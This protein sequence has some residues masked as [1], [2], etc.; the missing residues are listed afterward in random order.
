MKRIIQT[1]F[2]IFTI[3]ILSVCS[4][5]CVRNSKDIY[6]E[7]KSGL[8]LIKVER[9]HVL[10]FPNGDRMYFTGLSA[11]GTLENVTSSSDSIVSSTVYGTGFL[12]SDRGE[13]ATAHHVI[14]NCIDK[15][16][17]RNV[18]RAA[19]NYA[20]NDLNEEYNQAAELLFQL[21]MRQEELRNDLF[22]YDPDEEME[23]ELYIYALREKL[24]EYRQLYINLTSID[25]SRFDVSS[26]TEVGIAYNDTHIT[27][28]SDFISCVIVK[29]DEENDLA[30]I[31]LKDKFTP[32]NKY[33]F[34]LPSSDPIENYT[35]SE[36]I[37]R[38]IEKDKNDQLYLIGFNLGPSLALT[39]EGLMA[40]INQGGISQKQDSRLMYS[41]P[42]LPGSSG[43]PVVNS[44]GELVAV[45][46][47]GLGNTQ[48]FNYGIRVNLLRKLLK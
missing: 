26:V 34:S 28:D 14:S 4:I 42:A 35:F 12:I 38:H 25:P 41:I 37:M 3:F 1:I 16:E 22:Y 43:G 40:Q 10:T 5:S 30:V 24:E 9:H 21:N 8:V 32:S 18:I 47:A 39:S 19:I 29:E 6:E 48:S 44:R 17:V 20:K 2:Q 36:K 23:N 33:I 11:D 13:I 27:S 46:N 15:E 45:N 7:M 31:Q